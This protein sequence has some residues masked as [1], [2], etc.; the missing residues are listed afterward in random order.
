MTDLRVHFVVLRQ[1]KRSDSKETRTDPLWEFGS[2]GCTRCHSKNLMN[3][4]KIE[5][6][7]GARLAFAQGGPGQFR[8]VHV[9]PPIRTEHHGSFAEA[10]WRPIDMPLK[11]HCAPVLVNNDGYSDTPLI[12]EMIENVNQ[13]T[14]VSRFSSKFKTRCRPLT[15]RVLDEQ[16]VSVYENRRADG[17]KV[18]ECYSEAMPYPPPLIDPDRLGTHEWLLSL[19]YSEDGIPLRNSESSSCVSKPRPCGGNRRAC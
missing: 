9:T 6:L 11:F 12:L 10:I 13:P 3:P 7:D 8:L 16:I 19:E 18:A 4:R 15:C 17:A 5:E 2:F 1:P 14:P